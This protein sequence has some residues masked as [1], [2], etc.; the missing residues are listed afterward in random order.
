MD[1][2][3]PICWA[4]ETDLKGPA[5]SGSGIQ[6]SQNF[7]TLARHTIDRKKGTRLAKLGSQLYIIVD[8]WLINSLR[9]EWN[10]T[11]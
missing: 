2:L 8:R 6:Q 9:Y 1:Q 4:R 7:H 11:A 3:R 10:E 5:E